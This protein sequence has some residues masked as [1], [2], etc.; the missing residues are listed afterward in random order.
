M[1]QE[2]WEAETNLDLHVRSEEYRNLLLVMEMS[3]K[4]PEVRFDIISES[5]GIETIEKIRNAIRTRV[6]I[7]DHINRNKRTSKIRKLNME[8]LIVDTKFVMDKIGKPGWVIV[9]VSFREAYNK[10]HIPGAVGLPAWVSKL[11]AE[12]KKRH[13]S[14][15][16]RLEVDVRRDGNRQRQPYHRL[17]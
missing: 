12:D 11:F 8:N 7:L 6:K 13:D 5:K 4:P 1:L 10:G 14:V 3:L 2:Y 15:H 16:E 17:R 9:D